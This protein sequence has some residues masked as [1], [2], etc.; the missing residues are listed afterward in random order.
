MVLCSE[1]LVSGCNFSFPLSSLDCDTPSR[2]LLPARLQLQKLRIG[3][4]VLHYQLEC[5]RLWKHE[6]SR[7]SANLVERNKH[8]SIEYAKQ[9]RAKA[10]IAQVLYMYW[11]IYY[12][13]CI[14]IIHIHP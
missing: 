4:V 12:S 1:V 14:Y 2:D 7:M 10:L 13:I 11:Y 5:G 8:D 6:V 9:R 3:R